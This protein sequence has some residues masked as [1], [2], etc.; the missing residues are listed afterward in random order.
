MFDNRGVFD[1]W[2]F[3]LLL[4]NTNTIIMFAGI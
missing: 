4:A 2:V 1:G 3:T